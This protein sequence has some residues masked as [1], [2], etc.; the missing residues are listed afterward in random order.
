MLEY[1]NTVKGGFSRKG[2]VG[3]VFRMSKT[4]KNQEK[5]MFLRL[6]E[7]GA[8]GTGYVFLLLLLLLF[9]VFCFTKHE[10]RV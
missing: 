10:I 7:I 1:K 5:D 2:N 3:A 9:V 8:K 4:T 6:I